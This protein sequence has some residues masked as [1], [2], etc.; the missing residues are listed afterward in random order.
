[1]ATTDS[2]IITSDEYLSLCLLFLTQ[3]QNHTPPKPSKPQFECSVCGK[4]FSSYQALGGH[5]SSHRRPTDLDQIK[6]IITK[7]LDFDKNEGSHPHRCN[8]CHKTFS[9]GQALGGH[10]R[11]HYWDGSN[12]LVSM[13]GSVSGSAA[14]TFS[15]VRNFDLNLPPRNGWSEEE[16]VVSP[17]P[18]KKRRLI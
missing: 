13:S 16:E 4:S 5:K 18:V 15:I 2:H 17:L 7:P 8:V 14:S 6:Q 9:S 10:K 3:N 11:C 1:M 12:R